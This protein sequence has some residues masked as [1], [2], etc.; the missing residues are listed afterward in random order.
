MYLGKREEKGLGL[1]QKL[2]VEMNARLSP[3]HKRKRETNSS[4]CFNC[5][6]DLMLCSLDSVRGGGESE[7]NTV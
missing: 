3:L 2:L 4:V 1:R 6:S 5:G 7:E